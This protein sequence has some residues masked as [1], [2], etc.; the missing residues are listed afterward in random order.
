MKTGASLVPVF[1]FGENDI[2]DQVENPEGGALRAFLKARKKSLIGITSWL[3]LYGRPAEFRGAFL[4]RFFGKR[5]P[6]RNAQSIEVVFG[7][8]L[9]IKEKPFGNDP[10]PEDV[11]NTYHREY[12]DALRNLYEFTENRSTE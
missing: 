4:R 6:C 1:A 3:M 11:V 10:I 2:F 8:P 7:K 9:E 12:V 5:A